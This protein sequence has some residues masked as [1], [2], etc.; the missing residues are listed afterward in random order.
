M[1]GYGSSRWRGYSRRQ[2]VEQVDRLS[3]HALRARLSTAL[4]VREPRKVPDQGQPE[5]VGD[6]HIVVARLL[7]ER[8]G[9]FLPVA[10]TTW[11]RRSVT[12][13][14]VLGRV[15]AAFGGTR[16]RLCCPQCGRFCEALYSPSQRSYLCWVCRV[17][18]GLCYR[19]QQQ[20]PLVRLAHRQA[21]LASRRSELARTR[22][23]A[24]ARDNN[25]RMWLDVTIKFDALWLASG[26]KH[27]DRRSGVR[28]PLSINKESKYATG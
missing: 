21:R 19:S 23:C 4:S 13:V 20:A 7:E 11:G 10:V 15:P 25:A 3:V 9:A 12:E 28:S 22:R 1:G 6:V 8:E 26:R 18:L 16:W 2:T 27:I 5:H 17:C 14:V 24:R